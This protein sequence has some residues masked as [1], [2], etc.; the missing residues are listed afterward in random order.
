[1]REV[2]MFPPRFTAEPRD[3]GSIRSRLTCVY[4]QKGSVTWTL[5][6]LLHRGLGVNVRHT[7][8]CERPRVPSIRTKERGRC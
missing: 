3:G 1:M 4:F 6:L 7:R 8:A 5:F 2:L